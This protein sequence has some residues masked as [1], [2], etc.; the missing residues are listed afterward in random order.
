MLIIVF[1][2]QNRLVVTSTNFEGTRKDIYIRLKLDAYCG[3]NYDALDSIQVTPDIPLLGCAFPLLFLTSNAFHII[4]DVAIWIS[5]NAK[6]ES[7]C[8]AQ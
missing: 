2:Q 7:I 6:L 5:R 4:H 8:T 1:M 3:N